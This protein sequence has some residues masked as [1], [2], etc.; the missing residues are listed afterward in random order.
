MEI[1]ILGRG[2]SAKSMY[3]ELI[4]ENNVTY[5]IEKNEEI[6]EFSIYKDDVDINKYDYF[7]ISPGV[8]NDD[9]LF[10]RIKKNNKKFSSEIEYALDKLK[11]HKIIAIT[12]SNGKTTVAS[13]LHFVLNKKGVKNVVCGNIGDPL[14][15]YINV[16]IDTIIIL[17]ISSFQLEYLKYIKPYISI[18]TNISPNHLDRHA[19]EEYIELKKKITK[20]Q[21]ENDYL[22]INK[23]TNK[24]FNIIT[25]SKI[26]IVKKKS[27]NNKYLIG[28]HNYENFGF[29]IQVLKILKIKEYKKILK[30]FKGVKYRL[31]Y[32]GKYNKTKIYNDA[33]STTPYSTKAA[34]NCFGY[35]TLLIM[36]GKNKNIDYSFIEKAKIKKIIMYGEEGKNNNNINILKFDTLKDVF[37]YLKIHINEYKVILH[38]PG[39]T[40][41]DSYNNYKERGSEFEKLCFKYF[42]IK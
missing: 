7:F 10:I 36:G 17:E 25:K 34:V 41:F 39:F 38:S 24:Q 32:L 23:N 35:N 37:I 16:S 3:K 13:L 5:A 22:L 12:G 20:Y 19:F 29:V 1:L 15:N 40:S 9:E 27:I 2:I 6:D 4:K 31:E 26:K 28:N 30:E 18:I 33:K 8:K 11:N 14:V 42:K 21:D